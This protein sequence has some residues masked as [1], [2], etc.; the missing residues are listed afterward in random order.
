MTVEDSE[1]RRVR[2]RL[3]RAALV[4]LVALVVL[5][6]P[7]AAGKLWCR[8]DP[9]VSIDGNEV[10][11]L[12]GL[13]EKYEDAVN[14]PIMV[15]ITIPKGVPHQ[16]IMTDGGFNG[17]GEVVTFRET[18]KK[19][20]QKHGIKVQIK[21]RVPVDRAKLKNRD[22]V[23]IQLIIVKNN[24]RVAIDTGSIKHGAK[25]V[26]HLSRVAAPGH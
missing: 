5:A 23:P 26:F 18:N 10:Q 7:A 22:E 21:V 11:I 13:P 12:V 1:H 4:A 17:H 25:A 14:G 24:D 3:A 20:K 8:A 16:V 6:V 2:G 19:V 15:E 9:M